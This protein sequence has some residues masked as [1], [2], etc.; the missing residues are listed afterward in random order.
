MNGIIWFFG[1]FIIAYLV[2]HYFVC[3]GRILYKKKLKNSKNQKPIIVFDLHGVIIERRYPSIIKHI[4]KY[5]YRFDLLLLGCKPSF[6]RDVTKLLKKSRVPEEVIIKLSENHPRLEPFID[7]TI[8]MMNEQKIIQA[9]FEL[10]KKLKKDGYELYLFSNIGEKT[11]DKL[12]RKFPE[13][14]HYF[15]GI[16]VTEQQDDWIQKP[17]PQAFTKFLTRCG[18]K[19]EECIFIDNNHNNIKTALNEGFYSILFQ[20]PQQLLHELIAMKIL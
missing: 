14:F 10:I 2:R 13:I 7:V 12:K 18:L 1:A 11:F 15:D 19:P 5:A 9:T 17:Y 6:I 16:V 8:A 3:P 20:S 4:L